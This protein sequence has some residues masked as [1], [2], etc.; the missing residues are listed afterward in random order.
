MVGT[1]GDTALA[2]V[3]LAGFASFMSA[4]FFMGMS[5]G[6]QATA[7]RWLGADRTHEVAVP[8]NGGLTLVLILGIPASIIL[9]II[10]PSL[11]SLLSQDE[12]LVTLGIPYFQVRLLSIVGIGMNFAFRGYWSA[13]NRASLFMRTVVTTHLVNIFLNWVLI[14]G[15]LGAPPLGTL[16]AAIGT[17]LAIFL[18]TLLYF[19]LAW[20]HAKENGFLAR[21]PDRPTFF[22]LIR[23]SAPAGL[24]QF[25][26]ASGMTI[27]FWILGTIGTSELAAGNVLLNIMLAWILPANGFGI[28]AA[29]LVGQSLGAGHTQD[30]KAWAWQVARIAMLV[31]S[32][33]ALPALLFPN[34]FLSVFLHDPHTLALAHTPL[35]LIAFLMTFESMGI[36][37]VNA[38]FGAGHSRRVM[39]IMLPFQWGLFLPT[40][41]LIG[42]ALGFSFL[43]VWILYVTYRFAQGS[44]FVWSWQRGDWA[45][46]QV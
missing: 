44:V 36:V 31:V 9:F 40:A 7:A 13:V 35:R 8:L 27:F 1:L 18:G 17:T 43:A 30:A 5:A 29:S 34:P 28:A 12:Q 23:L 39:E 25:F 33:L 26:F 11:F 42:P 4:A 37:L 16:G 41:Y 22:N 10:A 2:A 45:K 46:V 20:R 6:V 24:Q 21:L 3:G 19:S 32:L 14:F 38:H 15:H